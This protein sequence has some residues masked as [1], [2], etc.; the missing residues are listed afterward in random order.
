MESSTIAECSH[1]LKIDSLGPTSL[2]RSKYRNPKPKT[3]VSRSRYV[4]P[5]LFSHESQ[6]KLGDGQGSYQVAF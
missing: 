6:G 3:D 2:I 4:K 1:V 5:V